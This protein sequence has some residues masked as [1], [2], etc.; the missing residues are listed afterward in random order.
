MLE[1]ID[2]ISASLALGLS[3][4]EV[5]LVASSKRIIVEGLLMNAIKI[6]G[7]DGESKEWFLLNNY[8]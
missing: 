6:V 4:K 7:L 1:S 8:I 2:K 5:E 3:Y